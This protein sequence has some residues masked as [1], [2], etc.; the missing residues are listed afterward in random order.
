MDGAG[1]LYGQPKGLVLIIPSV[2]FLKLKITIVTWDERVHLSS[3]GATGL[4]WT[5]EP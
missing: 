1:I 2:G 4:G 3:D 5:L